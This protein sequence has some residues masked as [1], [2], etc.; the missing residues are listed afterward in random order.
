MPGAA[1]GV[2]VGP[3]GQLPERGEAVACSLKI[4]P[5]FSFA[6]GDE[7]KAAVCM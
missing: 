7:L 4:T 1:M 3:H 5:N 2:M 6:R